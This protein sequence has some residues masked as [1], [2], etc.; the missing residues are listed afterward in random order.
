[1]QR[2]RVRSRVRLP[3]EC[4]S[5]V[6][7]HEPPG[8]GPS[9]DDSGESERSALRR[10]DD[11]LVPRLQA[12]ARAVARVLG[13][14]ARGLRAVD[15]WIGGGRPA[16]A[17]REHRGM[18]AFLTVALAFGAVAVHAQRYPQLQEEARQAAADAD[19]P[20]A[21]DAGQPLGD[22]V[23]PG[24][25]NDEETTGVV[26]PL[27]GSRVDPYLEERRAALA[28]VEDQERTAVISFT[29]FLA[30]EEVVEVV[31]GATV[32]LAQYRLPERTP[33]P[34]ELEV[35][36]QGLV[37]AVDD[38]IAEL[39]ADLR[40]E[41]DEVASTLESG[42]EDEAFRADYEARLDEL[43]GLR[44]T[45]SSD[46][47]IVFAVVV[48]APVT[49]LRGMADDEAVRLVDLAPVDA[50]VSSTTFFGVL[51]GDRDRFGFGRPT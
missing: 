47:A 10:I 41:E 15:G 16:R 29:G 11:S 20:T 48:T 5:A 4:M 7:P 40:V 21:G 8:A 42:V 25:G 37:A 9:K 49:A 23:V 22:A 45:L 2:P 31:G 19:A 6:E 39:V 34:A 12:V 50:D 44:N 46:P 3:G 13:L 43:K 28:A 24:G 18:A 36:D 38:T 33:R 32:H 27:A 30:P 17:V 51:P 14:P 26:G 1:M 35:D